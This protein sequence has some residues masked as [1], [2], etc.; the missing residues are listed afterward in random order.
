MLGKNSET[1]QQHKNRPHKVIN[2]KSKQT[3]FSTFYTTTTEEGNKPLFLSQKVH[4]CIHKEDLI[5]QFYKKNSSFYEINESV[6]F[7]L[8]I[9]Y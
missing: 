4:L 9:S 6:S 7:A 8:V 1:Q 3:Y 5:T 2:S